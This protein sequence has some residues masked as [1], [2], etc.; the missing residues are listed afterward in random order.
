MTTIQ[1]RFEWKGWGALMIAWSLM[2]AS[3]LAR[4]DGKISFKAPGSDTTVTLG[5]YVKLDAIW[6]SRSA[7]VDSVGDQQFNIN[8]V[9]VGPAAGQHKTDQVTL[10]ARQSRLSL[11]TITP[12][13]YGDLTTLVE[14]DFFG[15]D[16]NESVTNSNG[17]RI[18]HAYGTLGK[19]SA[20]QYWTNFFNEQ[21]FPE[22]VDFGGAVGEIFIRQAQV[23]WTEKL[24]AG[25][26]WSVSA[27]SPESL[28]AVPGSAVLFRADSDHAPDLTARMRFAAGGATYSAG[29]L[30]RNVHVDSATAPAADSG[31][32]GG[33]IALTG[34]IPA[35]GKDDLRLDVNLGNAIGR[36]QVPGFFPDG[37][38]DRNGSL[39]LARQTSGFIALR[40]FWKPSLRSTLELSAASSSPPAGTANG[41]NKSDR[42]EHLNLIWSPIPAVDLGA[43]LI[44]AQRAVVG[45]DKGSLNRIQFAAQYSF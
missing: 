23:R 14:G 37:Y 27:E 38:L 43:E 28:V 1:R 11:S 33:A 24:A 5:G 45:G 17:F 18:R 2:G 32:W 20:G 4:A 7:G 26:D 3:S 34:I 40:H 31:K 35:G 8:L 16:G 41:V 21:A 13:S 15:A 6:S 9:P 30:A 29:V 39:R 25:G 10:H 42:S 12:T 19:F 44:H 36:Y 22:T